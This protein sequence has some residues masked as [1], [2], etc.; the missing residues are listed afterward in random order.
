MI[1]TPTDPDHFGGLASVRERVTIGE[2]WDTAQGSEEHPEGR[3]ARHLAAIERAGVPIRRPIDLCREHDL[4]SGLRLSLLW[5]C[6]AFD[7]GLD[8]NDNSFVMRLKFGA[9]TILLTGDVEELA[10]HTLARE[11]ERVRA[12]I[13]KAAHHGSRTSSTEVFV[14]AVAPRLVISSQGRAHA[15]GHPHREV[16]ERF[17]RLGIPH[18]ATS[19]VGSITLRTRGTRWWIETPQFGPSAVQKPPFLE[20]IRWR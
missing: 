6:P 19:R 1:T 7:W 2:I 12:D 5:P 18:L 10:E 16:D 3:Y 17:R 11:P 20:P 8:P 14:R 13:L 4:G 15:F 9:R